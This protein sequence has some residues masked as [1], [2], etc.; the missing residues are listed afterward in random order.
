MKKKGYHNP[1]KARRVRQKMERDRAL[2]AFPQ[3]EFEEYWKKHSD[4]VCK[5]V[6]E[7]F[8]DTLAT[9]RIYMTVHTAFGQTQ[10]QEIH[11]GTIGRFCETIPDKFNG[12]ILRE[13]MPSLSHVIYSVLLNCDNMPLVDFIIT[14]SEK[15]ISKIIMTYLRESKKSRDIV[16]YIK[17]RLSEI[18]VFEQVSH[19]PRY[20]HAAER[21]KK[22]MAAKRLLFE[23]IQTSTPDDYT[24]LF[25]LARQMKRHFILHIGPTNSGKTYQA[26]QELMNADSGIYL[27][28]LRLLAYEQYEKMNRQ[29]CPCSMIT[30]EERI[31]MPGSFHQSS[32]IE[33]MNLDEDWDM[34]VIDEAQMVSDRQRG[35]SWTAAILGLKASVIHLCASPDAEK[36]LIRM[37]TS[38]GDDYEVQY[39]DRKTPL[40]M[41]D[42]AVDFRFPEDV[43]KGD[44]LIVFSRKDVHSVAAELQANG[45]TCS[46]IYG[47]LPYDVRHREAG[48]F[49]DGTTDVVVATDAIGMGMNL[50]VRRIVFLQTIKYDGV[51]ERPLTPSE[52][53]QIAGR[54]GRYGLYDTGYVTS[55]YDYEVIEKLLEHKLIP[56]NTAMINIPEQFLEKDGKVS[57]ILEL[58]NKIPAAEYYD[59]GDIDEKI[60]LARALE[61]IDDN[62]ELIRKFIRIP[63]NTDNKEIFDIY[64][65]YYRAQAEGE[66]VDL[67]ETI[68]Q[69][70]TAFADPEFRQSLQTLE[71]CS[72]VFD[73]LYSYTRLFGDEEDLPQILETKRAI[74]ERIFEILDLQKLSM[75]SCIYCGKKLKWSYRYTMCQECYRKH[76]Y[77]KYS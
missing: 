74:S 64:S 12:V 56:L 40:Q 17:P 62:R 68:R 53:K 67:Q 14:G 70:N 57:T 60:K 15:T 1:F 69:F 5:A 35:G 65:K 6:Y 33:M 21:H 46:I 27:A 44:A 39:H 77:R 13:M 72:A 22:T 24:Q 4:E 28:P 73:F 47:S 76:K 8:L 26:M 2:R 42:E 36:L 7:A 45:I 75:K 37:I 63:A 71:T 55:Y 50:P 18:V 49:A 10:K 58:W 19:N 38:C 43:K 61:A 3:E 51:K 32:T 59:K 48:K 29:G 30:G 9:D 41:D 34:A 25:P 54:A 31:L 20:I 66:P 52:V 11:K 23:S 16:D